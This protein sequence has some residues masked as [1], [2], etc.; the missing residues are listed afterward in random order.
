MDD[1]IAKPFRADDMLATIQRQI[2]AASSRL[3]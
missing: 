1:F 2:S 3:G